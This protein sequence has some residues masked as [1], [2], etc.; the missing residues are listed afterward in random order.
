M[1]ANICIFK[2]II[3]FPPLFK[4]QL[5]FLTHCDFFLP[6]NHERSYALTTTLRGFISTPPP[7]TRDIMLQGYS[8]LNCVTKSVGCS[9][10]LRTDILKLNPVVTQS[11]YCFL[12][13]WK[14][15][16][17]PSGPA[18]QRIHPAH[19][20]TPTDSPRADH[21]LVSL[22]VLMSRR[23]VVHALTLDD[24]E[25]CVPWH[26]YGAAAMWVAWVLAGRKLFCKERRVVVLTVAGECKDR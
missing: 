13:W 17:F 25:R 9:L 16:L 5:N 4:N 11:N 14:R 12:S 3:K 6:F 24:A 19:L 7:R 20:V 8:P 23:K 2:F 21:D 15:Y 10:P 1:G 18:T 26:G 22:T